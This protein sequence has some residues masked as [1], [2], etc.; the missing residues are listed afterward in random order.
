[1]AELAPETIERLR[2]A[3]DA[4][5]TNAYAPYSGF[6]VGAALLFE[7]GTVVTGCNVENISYS[8]TICA[9]RTALVRAIAT[10]GATRKIVA[11]M[12]ANLNHAA[13]SPCGACLQ[14]LSEFVEHDAVI[15]FPA[16]NDMIQ[17]PFHEL[18]PYAFS[19][20]QKE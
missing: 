7:D 13:S 3:A 20:W 19:N 11:V 12:I 5:A 2:V 16:A 17:K 18:L 8:L 4:A 9:E 15:W 10:E 6:R 1:M 14:M